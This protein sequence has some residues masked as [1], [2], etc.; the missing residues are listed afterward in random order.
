MRTYTILNDRGVLETCIY[1]KAASTKAFKMN[2]L[3][4]VEVLYAFLIVP[5]L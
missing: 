3:E 5:E 1:E 4:I 2:M